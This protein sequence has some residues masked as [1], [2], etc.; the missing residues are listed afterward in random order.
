MQ[1]HNFTINTYPIFIP[2]INNNKKNY[3][4]AKHDIV[5]YIYVYIDRWKA[6][7]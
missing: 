4:Y 7:T 2:I 6:I 3:Y 1:L 5:L